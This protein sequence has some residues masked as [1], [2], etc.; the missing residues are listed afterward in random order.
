VIKQQ[1]GFQKI[2]LRGMAKNRC[3]INV[4][5]ALTNSYLARGIYWLQHEHGIGASDWYWRGPKDIK[6]P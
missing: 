2:R 1:F 4:M 6:K 3:K 5:A